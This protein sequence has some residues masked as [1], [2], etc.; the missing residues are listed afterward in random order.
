MKL[1]KLTIS[2]SFAKFK[3]V[4]NYFQLIP[5]S[6]KKQRQ[7][8][9]VNFWQQ[10][11]HALNSSYFQPLKELKTWKNWE[12]VFL[13][14]ARIGFWNKAVIFQKFL[15]TS[16]NYQKAAHRS[17]SYLVVVCSYSVCLMQYSLMVG[18]M[19][20]AWPVRF[21]A[22]FS[23][24]AL[25]G[26]VFLATLARLQIILSIL[27]FNLVMLVLTGVWVSRSLGFAH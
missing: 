24:R 4:V 15:E 14:E 9:V 19:S 23:F 18:D 13:R 3:L 27:Y 12:N 1:T 5:V 17:Y 20:C 21:P 8:K 10:L 7:E 11:M 2:L 6:C 25:G 22:L 16:R 26:Q